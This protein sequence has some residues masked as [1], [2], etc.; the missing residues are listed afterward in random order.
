MIENRAEKFYKNFIETV[1]FYQSL[2]EG[3]GDINS[4]LATPYPLYK[5]IIL[6]QVDEKKREKKMMED[7]M[8]SNNKKGKTITRRVMPKN[9]PKKK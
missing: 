2:F 5:D 8:N 1:I 3:S 9:K 4:L 6:A 7:A